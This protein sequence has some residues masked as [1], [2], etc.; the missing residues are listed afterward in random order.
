MV[1]LAFFSCTCQSSSLFYVYTRRLRENYA[2]KRI[3]VACDGTKCN[4]VH[5]GGSG[6]VAFRA[7]IDCLNSLIGQFGSDT[8]SL[9]TFGLQF[10]SV[11]MRRS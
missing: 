11:S 4:L 8:L 1:Q 10:H 5:C 3:S 6:S 9:Q 2:I 7:Y